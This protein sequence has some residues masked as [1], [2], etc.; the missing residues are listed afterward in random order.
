M[1][2][3]HQ[4]SAFHGSDVS[5]YGFMKGAIK[6]GKANNRKHLVWRACLTHGLASRM[7]LLQSGVL[8]GSFIQLARKAE[9]RCIPSQTLSQRKP[10]QSKTS[11]E[12]CIA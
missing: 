12:T 1:P 9:D 10:V 2:G 6:L 7:Y 3:D 8:S 4:A 11:C 5:C